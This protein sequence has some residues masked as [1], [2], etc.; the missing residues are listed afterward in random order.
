MLERRSIVKGTCDCCYSDGDML[1]HVE[2]GLV[3]LCI[4]SKCRKKLSY[5]L[6]TSSSGTLAP[7]GTTKKTVSGGSYKTDTCVPVKDIKSR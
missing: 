2:L 1:L 6:A 5:L 3:N 7:G 4:C